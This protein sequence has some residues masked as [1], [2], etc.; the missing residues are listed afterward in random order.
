MGLV[1]LAFRFLRSMPP[2]LLAG[3]VIIGTGCDKHTPIAGGYEFISQPNMG[4]DS[5]PGASLGFHG[6]EVC[7]TLDGHTFLDCRDYAAFVHDDMIVFLI[8]MPDNDED[9]VRYEIS[10]QLCAMRGSGPPVVLSQRIL[11]RPIE[12]YGADVVCKLIPSPSG[13]HVEF[14]PG[15]GPE[16]DA[17]KATSVHDIPWTQIAQWLDTP[18][19]LAPPIVKPLGTYRLL[20]PAPQATTTQI[21]R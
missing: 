18:Q 1:A 5:H 10:P 11:G 21:S 17:S 13:V 16:I 2:L 7:H 6:K 20:P 15:P 9:H 12:T 8:T 4:P 3:L 14:C 19:A